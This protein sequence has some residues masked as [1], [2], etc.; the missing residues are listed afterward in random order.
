MFFKQDR[1]GFEADIQFGELAIVSKKSKRV[2]RREVG[3]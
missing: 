3:R 2:V 1:R